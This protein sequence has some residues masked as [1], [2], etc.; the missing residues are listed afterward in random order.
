MAKKDLDVYRD[1]LEI[2]DSNRPLN[3]YQLLKLKPFEDDAAKIRSSY[4]KLNAHVRRYASGEYGPQS[5]Q[6]LNELTKAMLCLT[7]A[8]RKREYDVT[9]GREDQGEGRRRTFE[10]SLLANK[11]L[12]PQQL[13]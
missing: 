10:E 9:L 5:Q 2:A 7:D 11:V 1:W 4:R 3:Y 8:Q 12:T 13:Q 6:L